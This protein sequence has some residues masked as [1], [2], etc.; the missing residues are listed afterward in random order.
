[1]K[2]R[3]FTLI[4]LLVV[5]AII[6]LLIG[7]LLPAL[8]KA[9]ATA[10]QMKDSTQVR[11]IQQAMAIWAGNNDSKYPL[12]SRMDLGNDTVNPAGAP[13]SGVNPAKDI[14]SNIYGLM[15]HNAAITPEICISP[16]E[17]AS[18]VSAKTNYEYSSPQAAQTSTKALWDPS[19]KGTPHTD[20]N[21]G[22]GPT[23]AT[24]TAH[25]SYAHTLPF[26]A[27]AQYWSDTFS[28]SQPA[29]ANRGPAYAA[30]D[31]GTL[32][33]TTARWGLL[34]NSRIG[35][36]SNTLGIHGGRT[37]WEGNVAYN[38]NHVTFET[39]P[40]PDSVTYTRAT[41]TVRAA[42]DNLFVMESDELSSSSTDLLVST[43]TNAYLRAYSGV[44][45]S[46]NTTTVTIS[47][48]NDRSTTG[49]WRD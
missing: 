44:T 43:A 47:S 12:P 33:S 26:G 10:R 4:E 17:T 27:R 9:R 15:I 16:A 39:K 49:T 23:N 45:F 11:G 40:N 38:D 20:D 35:D 21:Q 30:G 2:K 18:N 14:T 25:Q 48:G 41:G 22:T 34:Q 3:A 7:I 37:T 32:T 13:T 24:G 8:G 36:Q 31:T 28:A 6:A 1:M 46:S 29:I 19:F 42:S 5:I